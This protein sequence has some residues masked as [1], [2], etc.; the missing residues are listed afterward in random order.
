MDIL[1]LDEHISRTTGWF[2]NTWLDNETGTGWSHY[3][4]LDRVTE[5]GGTL[6]GVRALVRVGENRYVPN[7][8]KAIDWLKSTQQQNGGWKSWEI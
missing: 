5:W 1:K 6:E 4:G 8:A 3:A 7:I 2:Y